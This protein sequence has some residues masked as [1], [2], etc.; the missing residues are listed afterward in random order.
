MRTE[1]GRQPVGRFL[2]LLL[3]HVGTEVCYCR[4]MS[5][6]QAGKTEARSGALVCKAAYS[7]NNHRGVPM[8]VYDTYYQPLIFLEFSF[9]VF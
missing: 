9:R 7:N 5:R 1:P 2:L 3:V 6:T 8:V 4:E